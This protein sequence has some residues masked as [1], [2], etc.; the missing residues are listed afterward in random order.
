MVSELAYVFFAG[1]AGLMIFFI[2]LIFRALNGKKMINAP[3]TILLIISLTSTGIAAGVN[4]LSQK[5]DKKVNAYNTTSNTDKKDDSNVKDSKANE[6]NSKDYILPNSDKEKISEEEIAKFN[7]STLSLARNEIFA[8][9]GYVFTTPE[10][11]N[12]FEKKAWY[13]PDPSYNGENLNEIEKYNVELIKSHEEK[14]SENNSS[15]QVK[16]S[17]NKKGNLKGTVTWQYN[18][19][20][21]TKPDVGAKIYLIPEKF[22]KSSMTDKE[23]KPFAMLGSISEDKKGI[24]FFKTANGYGNYEINDIPVGKYV[25]LIVS[26]KTTRNIHEPIDDYPKNLLM[27]L[28]NDWKDFE[29][30][31]LNLYKF[32]VGTID[33]KENETIDE[34]YD[35]G[36]TY[37]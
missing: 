37:Y 33:I 2:S 8:R 10:A 29:Y 9:H 19:V 12:Y 3:L 32:T 1:L 16:A 21:G 30:F 22:N 6:T 24:L 25:I 11:K 35:F 5:N 4:M 13:K 31:N 20:I 36:Y 23:A 17:S 27:P 18:K 34:S 26:N 28:V 15:G 7:L 14:L